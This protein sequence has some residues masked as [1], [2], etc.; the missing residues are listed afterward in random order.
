[1]SA[2]FSPLVLFFACAACATT[3]P[4]L[5]RGVYPSRAM[6]AP[7]R[8]ATYTPPHFGDDERLPLVIFLHGGGDSHESF[9]RHGIGE[10]LDRAIAEGRVP[11]VVIALPDGQLGFWAN[12]RDRTHFYEDWVLDELLPHVQ[13]EAHTLGCP[14]GCHV[15]G[16]SMGGAGTIQFALHRPELF[17]SAGI[18]S[19]PVFDTDA[20][21]DFRDNRLLAM[22]IPTHRVFGNPPR[23]VVMQSDPFHR[24]R[25]PDDTPR[26]YVAWAR[27]DRDGIVKSSA[28]LHRHLAAHDIPHAHDEFEGGHNWPSWAPVIERALAWQLGD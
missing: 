12:W 17:A 5:S 6:H 10:R 2:R 19:A 9:D 27:G 4:R 23:T 25:H 22:L 20:M 8:Y 21:Y 3:T 28:R 13:R 26:L 15:M 24:W 18:I 7:M 1:L 11:R 16:V 14:D